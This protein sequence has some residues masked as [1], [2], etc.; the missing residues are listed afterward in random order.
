MNSK[1]RFFCLVLLTLTVFLGGCAAKSTPK[2]N[3]KPKTDS[4]VELLNK[5]ANN[6]QND[7]E[8]LS[9]IKKAKLQTKQKETV[10]PEVYDEPTSKQL[11]QKISFSWSGPLLVALEVLAE[12]IGYR[13][14]V[15]GDKPTQENII[16]IHE[17]EKSVFEILE[18]IGW[19]TNS[20]TIL[21]LDEARKVLQITYKG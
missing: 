5:A 19:K 8:T 17:N 16:T 14:K 11:T 12:K 9:K 18:D 6:I 2:T 21:K 7:L 3:I 10:E 4:S 1:I 13:F 15:V 20:N